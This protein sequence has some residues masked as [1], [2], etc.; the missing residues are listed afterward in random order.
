MKI[1]PRAVSTYN[2]VSL[3]NLVCLYSSILATTLLYNIICS[4]VVISP[5]VKAVQ[6]ARKWTERDLNPQPHGYKPYALT[7]CAI[8]PFWNGYLHRPPFLLNLN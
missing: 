5:T 8:R 3:Y 1:N 7:D 6:P 2:A 4:S